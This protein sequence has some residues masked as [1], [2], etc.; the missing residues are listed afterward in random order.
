MVLFWKSSLPGLAY[1]SRT[2]YQHRNR[3]FKSVLL[4]RRVIAWKWTTVQEEIVKEQD[5]WNE[6]HAS[7]SDNNLD[8]G[9][10]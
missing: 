5:D 10:K 6:D 9:W 4:R 2:F 1:E 3:E 8:G 7:E